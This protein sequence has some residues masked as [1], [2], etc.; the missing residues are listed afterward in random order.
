MTNREKFRAAYLEKLTDQVAK[1]PE[2]YLYPVEQV[3][4]VCDKM[5]ASLAIGQASNSPAIKA[6]CR[7]LGIKSTYSA[8][9]AYLADG[10]A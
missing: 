5:I 9:K 8:I 3:P 2:E 10:A 1:H 4:I 7:A 6:V